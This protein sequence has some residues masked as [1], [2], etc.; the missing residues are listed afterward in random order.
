MIRITSWSIGASFAL[1]PVVLA[2][3]S[4]SCSRKPSRLPTPSGRWRRERRAKGGEVRVKP[5]D[6]LADVEPVGE[7][8]DL[9]R[10]AL[11]VERDALGELADRRAQTVALLDKPVRRPLGD[12]IHRLL[13]DS[14]IAP[15][16]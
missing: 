8:G 11:L 7:N 10:Q 3:R 15:S 16:R 13:D 12:S 5:A 9:L 14:P 6:L 1:L 2:S 4:S